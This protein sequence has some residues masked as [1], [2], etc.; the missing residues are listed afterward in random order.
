MANG[1][2][3]NHDK[4]LQIYFLCIKCQAKKQLS[5]RCRKHSK[6]VCVSGETGAWSSSEH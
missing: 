3:L 1:F 5:E 2:A 6:F 4:S